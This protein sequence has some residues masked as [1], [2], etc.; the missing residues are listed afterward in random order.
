LGAGDMFLVTDLPVLD[1]RTGRRLGQ[2]DGVELIL[3][4]RHAGTVTDQTTL[5]LPG[6]HV[7]ID[8]IIRHTDAPLRMTVTG[9]TGRYAGVSGQ[10]TL[11]REDTDRKVSVMRLTL[12][13]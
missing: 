7:E 12:L 3:S 9:G 4:A 1:G 6:G 13:R 11:L 5:R 8:G 10:L 2:S